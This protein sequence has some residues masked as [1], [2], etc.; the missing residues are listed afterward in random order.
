MKKQLK[1]YLIEK[2]N[3]MADAYTCH[4]L[5]EE[6]QKQGI[7]LKMIGIF[8]IRD[9]NGRLYNGDEPL[10]KRDFVINRFKFGLLKNEINKLADRQYNNI[11]GLNTYI[12][13][14]NQVKTLSSE[15]YIIPKYICA[16]LTLE[17]ERIVSALGSPFVLK[18][19]ESSE[20][21][22]VFL[23]ESEKDY[24]KIKN[25]NKDYQEWLF[26]E[27]IKSSFG[28]DM[29]FYSVKGVPVACMERKSKGDFR[30][31]V[32]LGAG[33]REI[34][35]TE[36]M[37]KAAKDIYEKTGLD[38]LGIDLLYGETEK[39]YFCEIN[40]MAG[41]SGIEKATGINVAGAVLEAI[42]KDF[43]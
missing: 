12:N 37:K 10:E 4:R 7:D 16:P 43:E 18:G 2:Y 27:Y 38:F 23:I 40:V 25:E 8:D 31:N 22:E 21:K 5:L 30:A 32:A 20:G 42:A 15:A 24:L 13:K 9:E 29:R 28:R 26:E 19:L 39:P 1:G 11:D 35:A 41:M 6:A 34:E 33:V 36:Y 14:Y 3:N 17:Y